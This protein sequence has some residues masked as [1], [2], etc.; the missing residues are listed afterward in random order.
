[1]FFPFCPET[2]GEITLKHNLSVESM[3]ILFCFY[4]FNSLNFTGHQI[5]TQCGEAQLKIY[6]H[7]CLPEGS[8][9]ESR[10][11]SF[12]CGWNTRWTFDQTHSSERVSRV[13][14]RTHSLCFSGLTLSD[15]SGNARLRCALQYWLPQQLEASYFWLLVGHLVGLPW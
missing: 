6:E 3:W 5:R 9:F 13:N 14:F 4:G 11:R 8:G 1:M 10:L 2:R 15:E 12:L 7:I